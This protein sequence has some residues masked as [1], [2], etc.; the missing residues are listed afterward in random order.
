MKAPMPE[1][2]PTMT[3]QEKEQVVNWLMQLK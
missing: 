3:Q 2:F 1:S